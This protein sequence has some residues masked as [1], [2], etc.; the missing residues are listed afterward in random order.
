MAERLLSAERACYQM[1]ICYPNV[2]AHHLGKHEHEPQKLSFQPCCV[3]HLENDTAL[4][5]Y[6]FHTHQPILIIFVDNKVVLL[7]T[8]YKYYLPRVGY[9]AVRIG[10]TPFPDRRL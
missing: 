6:I 2:S 5:C 10:P 9:G 3:Q 8:V 1:M 4:A 7:S